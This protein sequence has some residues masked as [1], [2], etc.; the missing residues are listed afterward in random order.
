VALVPKSI[1]VGIWTAVMASG[2]SAHTAGHW[3]EVET[4]LKRFGDE[5]PPVWSAHLNSSRCGVVGHRAVEVSLLLAP[6]AT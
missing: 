6:G 4:H 3:P 1:W 5:A 2:A